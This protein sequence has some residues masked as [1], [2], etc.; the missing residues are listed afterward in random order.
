MAQATVSRRR[1]CTNCGGRYF[2]RTI[3]VFGA[4]IATAIALGGIAKA[5][6]SSGV[7]G[8]SNSNMPDASNIFEAGAWAVGGIFIAGIIA[9]VASGHR[10]IRCDA[11]Q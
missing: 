5:V 2:V 8:V 7:I 1:P 10:C 11:H 4:L 3:S 6:M 9:V